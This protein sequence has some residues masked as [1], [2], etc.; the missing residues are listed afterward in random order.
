MIFA[1]YRNG[2][3]FSELPYPRLYPQFTLFFPR[4]S[5]RFAMSGAPFC[6]AWLAAGSPGAPMQAMGATVATLGGL[7]MAP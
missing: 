7:E 5:A 3:D 6:L 2:L 1:M 4:K